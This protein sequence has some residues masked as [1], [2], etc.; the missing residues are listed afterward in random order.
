MPNLS[1]EIL[2]RAVL[3]S[4]IVQSELRYNLLSVSRE[5]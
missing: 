3:S 1:S 2:L 5:L 4:T